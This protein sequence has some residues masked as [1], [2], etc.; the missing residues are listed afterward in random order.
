ML[1]GMAMTDGRSEKRNNPITQRDRQC[2]RLTRHRSA[3]RRRRATVDVDL[4][5][6]QSR[7]VTVSLSR[8]TASARA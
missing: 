6:P 7:S 3:V 4:D 1:T 2:L 8:L 5:N